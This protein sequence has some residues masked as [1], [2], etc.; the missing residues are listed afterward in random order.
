M[1]DYY[2]VTS[3]DEENTISLGLFQDLVNATKRRDDVRKI[4][5][6]ARLEPRVGQVEQ[7]WIDVTVAPDFDW[8]AHLTGFT[9]H[10][11]EGH[12]LPGPALMPHAHRARRPHKFACSR[13]AR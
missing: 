6:D 11:R 3:G 1:N 4:G 8:H 9:R 7:Y 2:V 13:C 10:R 5:F 12:G